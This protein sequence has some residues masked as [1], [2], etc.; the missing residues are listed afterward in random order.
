MSHRDE[1]IAKMDAQLREWS[2]KIDEIQARAQKAAAEGRVEIQKQFETADAKRK[3]LSRR[4]GE[5]RAASDEGFA[6][7]R[8]GF[9]KTWKEF[10][11]A[12]EKKRS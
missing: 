8:S 5:L 11:S 1:Y 6:A 12:F 9:E 4:L 7:L 2:A 3:E 10:T